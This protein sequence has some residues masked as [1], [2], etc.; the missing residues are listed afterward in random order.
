MTVSNQKTIIHPDNIVKPGSARH[1]HLMGLRK[2]TEADRKRET[3]KL[4]YDGL[5]LIDPT[6]YGLNV[7]EETL[8]L[9]LQGKVATFRTKPKEPQS[10]DRRKPNY[11]PPMF[12]PKDQKAGGMPSAEELAAAKA[13]IERAESALN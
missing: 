6:Q 4:E 11:A 10:K 1:M 5:T 7:R 8:H 13:V 9:I 3:F 2:V 12:L